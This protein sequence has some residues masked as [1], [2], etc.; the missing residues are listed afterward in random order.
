MGILIKADFQS[1]LTSKLSKYR[2]KDK[3][4]EYQKEIS[5]ELFSKFPQFKAH[6]AAYI[7]RNYCGVVIND[8]EHSN[9]DTLIDLMSLDELLMPNRWIVGRRRP[10]ILKQK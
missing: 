4:P 9:P 7:E 6:V 10:R 2:S 8:E 5:Y 1:K 3:N